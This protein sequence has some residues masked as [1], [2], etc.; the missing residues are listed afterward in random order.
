MFSTICA[1]CS[2]AIAA[3]LYNASSLKIVLRV[4]KVEVD[5]GDEQQ[6]RQR[7]RR[8][9]LVV[10]AS[11]HMPTMYEHVACSGRSVQIGENWLGPI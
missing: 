2:I 6:S 10:G 3:T 7:R 1:L 9:R 4:G 11:K 5:A 8:R